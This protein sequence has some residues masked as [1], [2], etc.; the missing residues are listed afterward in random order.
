MME[1]VSFGGWPGCVRIFNR[2]IDL[3]VT[4]AVGPRIIRC[5]FVNGP[6]L[7]YV[8]EDDKGK[9]G[10]EDW[11]IYGGHRLWHAPEVMPRTYFPD[12][13]PVEYKWNGQVLSVIQPVE[14]T[15]GII[16]GLDISLHPEHN[17]VRI[18]HRLT[19]STP[20][21]IETAPWAITAHA[22]GS[23]VI[24]PQE[25]Y[26]DPAVNLLPA[27]PLV[28]W[29]Y[30]RMTDSRWTFGDAFIRLRHED[31]KLQEQKI[32]ILNKQGWCA[33][34]L[35]NTLILKYF[36]YL[37]DA[38]YPDFCSNNEVWVNGYFLETETLGPV[39]AISPGASVTHEENWVIVNIEK[40]PDDMSDNQISELIRPYL[41]KTYLH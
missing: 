40:V 17:H 33:V 2:D 3:I 15:T 22:P 29:N 20:W 5:G 6:N 31:G 30:T 41:D 4:T 10:G 38:E 28:L 12:N 26:I 18:L 34:I 24:L 36:S 11:R 25:P 7:F 35:N 27:R 8:S 32:G 14:S 16:K 21:T 13:F 9:S 39:T 23:Q 37:P 1:I 19:N